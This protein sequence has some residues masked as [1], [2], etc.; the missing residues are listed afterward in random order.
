MSMM[1]PMVLLRSS[2]AGRSRL[3]LITWPGRTRG[4]KGHL[5]AV[6]GLGSMGSSPSV[7]LNP[8][9][10]GLFAPYYSSR[11]LSFASGNSS[12]VHFS[13]TPVLADELLEI[14]QVIRIQKLPI[15]RSS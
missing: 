3:W 9:Q 12:T 11:I 10:A 4:I 13:I 5:Q 1:A 2:G 14:M 8:G 7:S 6:V 15:P